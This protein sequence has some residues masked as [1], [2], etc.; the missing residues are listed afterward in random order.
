MCESSRPNDGSPRGEHVHNARRRR[1]YSLNTESY[2]KR[3]A[4]YLEH[5]RACG[6]WY[7]ER[8]IK[9]ARAVAT[10]YRDGPARM[11]GLNQVLRHGGDGTAGLPRDFT[12]AIAASGPRDTSQVRQEGVRE[13]GP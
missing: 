9:H 13:G 2:L 6:P 5:L 1:K 10:H 7:A 11:D 12:V 3:Y 4:T 8:G